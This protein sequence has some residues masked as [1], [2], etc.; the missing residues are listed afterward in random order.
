[1]LAFTIRANGIN[2]IHDIIYLFIEIESTTAPGSK[3]RMTPECLKGQFAPIK[4][5]F[6]GIVQYLLPI[7]VDLEQG[8]VYLYAE[9]EFLSQIH[10]GD[11]IALNGICLTVVNIYPDHCTFEISEE[12][13]AKTTIG[14]NPERRANVELS[15]KYGD[16]LGGHI[17]SGHVHQTALIESLDHQGNLWVNLLVNAETLVKFKGSIAIDGVS[18]T[19]AEIKG[20]LI[21]IAL[22]PETLARTTLGLACASHQVNI[23]FDLPTGPPLTPIQMNPHSAPPGALSLCDDSYCM[24]L[25]LIEGQKGRA[26]APPNPWVGVVIVRDGIILGTGY[27]DCPGCPH[28][29]VNAIQASGDVSGAT[30]YTTL[31]PC[32]HYGRTPPCVDLIIQSGLKR[33]VVG[34]MDPDP[35]VNGQGINKL[36]QA[37]LKVDFCLE[38]E[39]QLNLRLYLHVRKTGRPYY[40]LK[41]ALSV[42][43]CYR[44]PHHKWISSEASQRQAHIL[45]S[46]SQTIIVGAH[47]VIQDDPQLN[48]RHGIAYTKEPQRWVIDGKALREPSQYKLF[49]SGSPSTIVTA[50]PDKWKEWPNV[51]EL[52]AT[53]SGDVDLRE[54]SPHLLDST[55]QCLVEGGHRIQRCFMELGLADELVIFRA[56]VVLGHH[57]YLWSVPPNIKLKLIQVEM[58][59]GD[60]MERYHVEC[61]ESLSR[62]IFEPDPIERALHHFANGGMVVVVDDESRENEGDLIVAAAH[63]TETQMTEM[64]N[65]TT[66]IICVPM[67]A[68]R[69]KKLNLP[70]M[71]SQNTDRHQTAFTVSVDALKTGTGVSSRDR[72]TT[73]KALADPMTTARDFRRPG[74]IFPL[75]ANPQG[76]RARR[77]HTEAA[78]TLCQL[79]G[80]YPHVSVISE[81]QNPDGTMRNR[82]QSYAYA[83]RARIP[84][85]TVGQLAEHVAKVA[86][87]KILSECK[88]DSEI[89]S[90]PWKMLCLDSGDYYHPH[91]VL[92]YGEIN[93]ISPTPVRIHSECFTGDVFKSKHCDC[94]KQLLAAMEYI[95][96][97]T[98]GVIIFPSDH[99]GRGIGIT[100]KVKA[101]Q[102]QQEQGL[103]TFESN[104]FLGL[105]VDGRTYHDSKLILE[106]LGL[107][108]I[109]LLT[110]NP[111]KI[112]ALGEFVIKTTPLI[113]AA[114]NIN[115]KY[116]QSKK[117]FFSEI[118]SSSAQIHSQPQIDLSNLAVG[119]LRV[120]IVRASWH[121]EQIERICQKLRTYLELLGVMEIE[122]FSV[123]GS[124]EIPLMAL[125]IAPRYHA[126]IG[127]G[128]LLKGD[129]L[130]FENVSSAVANGLMQ[131]QLISGIPIIN[132]ILSCMNS[133]QVEARIDGD[134]S[135]LD[136][137]AQTAIYMAT[138]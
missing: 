8:V 99:E 98:A 11:S 57:G 69:A 40:L 43:N 80:I 91:K 3:G 65:Q 109:D 41:I 5:M 105:D 10:R 135:T 50:T 54:I 131:A 16:F 78:V 133:S 28:A 120:G 62:I 61:S 59:D 46:E 94:G 21:R 4:Q 63:M 85:I 76:L 125:K 126:V 96:A 53:V 51:L 52:P 90:N 68:N 67:E 18:L 115:Q 129:T 72:L 119:H 89:G 17:M 95:V 6:T 113:I 107:K 47:T 35:R 70:P 110:E 12:T 2:L 26:S 71:C 138:R 127:V 100:D 103:N 87:I 116:L 122:E 114:T 32:C 20:S 39:V 117:D 112:L 55:I 48:I 64:L 30:L 74:H 66:G 81:L 75:V 37:G 93:T 88:I 22:I 31:E 118:V 29:E 23:E 101:Y 82:E 33:V 136:Y 38:A 97:A 25:A 108:Q 24:Q 9:A 132:C 134:Q 36:R 104:Q 79:T 124:N 102:I 13:I 42:D 27:H 92:I 7:R 73:I 14:L 44:D 84:I 83:Q 130:H 58:I 19:V 106:F 34:V 137:I 60:I 86:P 121:S 45:R 15:L 128:I 56:P 1:M 77:G 111:I 123:P 49:K